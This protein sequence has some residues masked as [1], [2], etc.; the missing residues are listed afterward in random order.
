MAESTANQI[1]EAC[2]GTGGHNG[3]P[4]RPCDECDGTG[5]VDPG[6]VYND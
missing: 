1:C 2:D 6:H 3:D 5:F 4:G